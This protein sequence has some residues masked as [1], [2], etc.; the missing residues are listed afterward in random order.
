MLGLL[1]QIRREIQRRTVV[2]GQQREAQHLAAV[3]AQQ[4]ADRAH[5]AQGLGHLLAIHVEEGVV[6]PVAHELVAVGTAA[7]GQ[8][9]LVVRKNQV[10]AAAV[11]IDGRPR[12]ARIIAEHSRCQPG[13]PRPQGLSQPGSSSVEGFQS[14]KSPG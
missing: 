6:H 2:R 7:L 9:V 12:C 1:E 5:V 8:F 4:L 14:T 13:R 3:A 10:A 11:D